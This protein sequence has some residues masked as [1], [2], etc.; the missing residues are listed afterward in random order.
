MTALTLQEPTL[1]ET[2]EQVAQSQNTSGE[3][4][5]QIAVSEYLNR[6]MNQKILAESEAFT[7]LYPDLYR[8]YRGQ[9]VAI[10]HGQLVDSDA[11]LRTLH[12]RIRKQFGLLP[13]LLRKVTEIQDI[14]NL[15]FRSTRFFDGPNHSTSYQG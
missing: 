14:P 9:Y 13:V 2:L 12:L 4:L 15:Q 5:L 3:A 1:V 6:V 7:D 8:Q 10:H 11:D